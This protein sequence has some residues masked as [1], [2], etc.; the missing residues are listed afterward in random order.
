MES[1]TENGSLSPFT[2]FPLSVVSRVFDGRLLVKL[3]GGLITESDV[4]EPA[5][6]AP[7]G[8]ATVD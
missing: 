1:R 3:I 2:I 8:G 4:R 7:S 5:S 6:G